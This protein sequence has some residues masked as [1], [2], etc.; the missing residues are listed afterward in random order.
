VTNLELGRGRPLSVEEWLGLSR[1]LRV[2][3]VELLAGPGAGS[4]ELGEVTYTAEMLR[5]LLDTPPAPLFDAR[6]RAS[7]AELL[8]LFLSPDDV[9]RVIKVLDVVAGRDVVLD[10]ARLTEELGATDGAR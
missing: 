4:T 3:P 1:A 2:P 6:G 7:V 9:E 8:L 5:A 10:L